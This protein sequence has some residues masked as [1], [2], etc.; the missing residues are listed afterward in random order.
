MVFFALYESECL[1]LRDIV[2]PEFY[3]FCIDNIATS[4]ATAITSDKQADFF[5]SSLKSVLDNQG[6]PLPHPFGSELIYGFESFEFKDGRNVIILRTDTNEVILVI[7]KYY[8]TDQIFFVDRNMMLKLGP[9]FD[10]Q[11]RFIADLHEAYLQYENKKPELNYSYALEVSNSRPWHALYPMLGVLNEVN[12]KFSKEYGSIPIY[13]VSNKIFIDYSQYFECMETLMT[14]PNLCVRVE[15][16]MYRRPPYELDQM[17]LRGAKDTVFSHEVES[18]IDQQTKGKL[19]NKPIIW[20]SLAVEKR[21]LITLLDAMSK[22]IT[23]M[24]LVFPDTLLIFDGLTSTVDF[25][26]NVASTSFSEDKGVLE[27]LLNKLLPKK[28][29]Y[30]HSSGFSVMQK[31]HLADLC[32]FFISDSGTAS[33]Y[34]DRFA[35]KAGVIFQPNCW[36]AIEHEHFNSIAVDQARIYDIYS[37]KE[38]VNTDFYIEPNYLA[39]FCFYQ[40]LKTKYA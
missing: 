19:Y 10:E 21:Q 33:M 35:Q 3:Q 29:N 14:R 6:F 31:M 2:S 32:D 22:F 13:Y 39:S 11:N 12:Q 17:L 34:P 36:Y 9:L 1:E 27:K 18:I 38:S 15:I 37:G 4:T 5:Y 25:K 23:M 20:I 16:Q 8:Y 40:F 26:T 24:I 7:Q 28:L 30:I